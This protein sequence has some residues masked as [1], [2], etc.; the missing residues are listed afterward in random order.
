MLLAADVGGTKTRVALFTADGTEELAGEQYQSGDFPD[1]ETLIGTFLELHS[2]FLTQPIRSA[3]FGIPGPVIN[4]HVRV[5]NLPWEISEKSVKSKLGLPALLLVNDLVATAAGAS[6][7]PPETVITLY[8]GNGSPTSGQC[9]LLVAPGTG[10]GHAVIVEGAHRV[11]FLASEAGHM[12]FAPTTPDER[13]LLVYVEELSGHARVESLVSGPGIT[14]IHDFF[15][16]QR[17]CTPPRQLE[18]YTGDDDDRPA[19]VT[20]HAI[21]K[22]DDGCVQAMAMFCRIF[23]AHVSN[24]LLA[25][26]STRGV[27]LG[28]GVPPRILP[29]LQ[30]GEFVAG[31]LAKTKCR[32]QVEAT[33][34]TVIMNDSAALRG[35]AMLARRSA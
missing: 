2:A 11:E 26:L 16:A 20:R 22:S 18:G 35:A 25:T 24:M 21:A 14:T 1:L 3:C 17:S 33:P 10:L 19:L 29:L 27:M 23:G 28:G 32:E 5:T 15:V 30:R 13:N 7:L 9:S 8:P 6:T 34:V 4:G 12:N 31:Y